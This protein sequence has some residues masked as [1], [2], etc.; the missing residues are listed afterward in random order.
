M[1]PEWKGKFDECVKQ[2]QRKDDFIDW[3]G[4]CHYCWNECSYRYAIEGEKG[5]FHHIDKISNNGI[6]QTRKIIIEP[7]YILYMCCAKHHKMHHNEIQKIDIDDYNG[8]S[9]DD[10]DDECTPRTICATWY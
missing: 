3:S 2:L 7:R 1:T 10:N 4:S 9:H 6:I 5:L 8:H